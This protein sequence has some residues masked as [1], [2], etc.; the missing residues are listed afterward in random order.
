MYYILNGT[1]NGKIRV[2]VRIVSPA[3][4]GGLYK[5][6][7]TIKKSKI[8]S[9]GCVRWDVSINDNPVHVIMARDANGDL[10]LTW[11]DKD[12]DVCTVKMLRGSQLRELKALL[13]AISYTL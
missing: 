13:K 2:L 9:Y 4:I 8:S 1:G 7:L 6:K 5:M 11:C 3:Y 10:L 12:L